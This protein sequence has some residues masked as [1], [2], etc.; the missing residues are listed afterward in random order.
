ML[1]SIHRHY[2]FLV[3]RSLPFHLPSPC[4]PRVLPAGR[5]S[6]SLLRLVFC[7]HI[8]NLRW[9]IRQPHLLTKLSTICDTEACRGRSC[10][11]DQGFFTMLK[12]EFGVKYVFATRTLTSSASVARW[13]NTW[14]VSSHTPSRTKIKWMSEPVKR[15]LT[16]VSS[17]NN[18][19]SL[20]VFFKLCNLVIKNYSLAF[21]INVIVSQVK[22]SFTANRSLYRVD[23]YFSRDSRLI[24]VDVIE[25]RRA[26]ICGWD[27][28]TVI[29]KVVNVC[30]WHSTWVV[31]NE[32]RLLPEVAGSSLLWKEPCSARSTC[33]S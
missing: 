6:S 25:K 8:K 7:I 4:L 1:T 29:R 26:K 28:C 19:Q 30:L 12:L 21:P 22:V 3:W 32:N 23:N 33:S 31:I 15:N 27:Y 16:I 9:T 24:E 17:K 18:W 2:K 11:I 14:N 5:S 20:T 10:H 13:Y